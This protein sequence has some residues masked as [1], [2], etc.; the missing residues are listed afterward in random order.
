MS[1][2][3]CIL[4]VI[5][6]SN[7][8]TQPSTTLHVAVAQAEAVV[9]PDAMADDLGRK[10]MVCVWVKWCGCVHSSPKRAYRDE[11]RAFLSQ[12]TLVEG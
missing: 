2:Y 7:S 10:A 5:S 1:F 9:E 8:E 3:V 12:G 4:G 6:Q 11:E